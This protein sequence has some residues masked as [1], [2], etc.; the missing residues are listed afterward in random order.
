MRPRILIMVLALG[1]AAYVLVRRARQR[2]RR[3][4]LDAEL[5][6]ADRFARGGSFANDSGEPMQ[7]FDQADAEAAQDVAGPEP[8]LDVVIIEGEPG[9][10]DAVVIELEEQ[11]LGDRRARG[12]GGRRGL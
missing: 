11:D 10:V 4:A 6:R 2:A 3:A 5:E 8:D 1:L 12:D 9:T 7:A